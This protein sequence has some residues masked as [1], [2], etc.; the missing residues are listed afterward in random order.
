MSAAVV[1]GKILMGLVWLMIGG[2]VFILFSPV[3]WI[4]SLKH[5]KRR[6][7]QP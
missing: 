6:F 7:I 4:L 2:I 1:A 3:A 5:E